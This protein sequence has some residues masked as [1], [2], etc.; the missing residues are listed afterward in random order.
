MNIKGLDGVP[1]V[2]RF[3]HNFKEHVGRDNT[4]RVEGNVVIINEGKMFG[5]V[6]GK[7]H[8]DNEV[9]ARGIVLAREGTEHVHVLPL[10]E[11]ER[12]RQMVHLHDGLVAVL[13]GKLGQTGL[14][15]IV[16]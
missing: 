11:L 15:E 3:Q 7:D 1:E 9:A 10:Q 13:H 4:L 8:F 5:K 12:R 14:V 2:R 6:G 16:E